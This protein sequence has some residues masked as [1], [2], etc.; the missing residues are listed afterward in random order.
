MSVDRTI[1]GY[2]FRKK[3][4]DKKCYLKYIANKENKFIAE[5]FAVAGVFLFFTVPAFAA[6]NDV[7][8]DKWGLGAGW[9]IAGILDLVAA[10]FAALPVVAQII[11]K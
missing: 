10:G 4:F 8:L 7:N 3:P 2:S 11:K 1:K 5:L 6:A 9:V